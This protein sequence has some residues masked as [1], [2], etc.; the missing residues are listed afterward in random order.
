MKVRFILD[1]ML[2]LPRRPGLLGWNQEWH[3]V[4]SLLQETNTIRQGGGSRVP[5]IESLCLSL[6]GLDCVPNP[7]NVSR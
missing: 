1:Y 4:F 2:F 3:I 7:K 6:R 5:A